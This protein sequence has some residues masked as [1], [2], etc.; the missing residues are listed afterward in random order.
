M[1]Q[2]YDADEQ[3]KKVREKP[4][5]RPQITERERA[6]IIIGMTEGLF[7]LSHQDRVRL[8]DRILEGLEQARSDERQ[9]LL[10]G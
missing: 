9:L 10:S 8:H 6:Y 2:E 5:L 1:A 4:W 3:R 7:A